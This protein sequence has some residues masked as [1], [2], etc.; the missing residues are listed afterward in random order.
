[1]RPGFRGWLYRA[2]AAL[3]GLAGL[4]VFLTLSELSRFYGFPRFQP[5]AGIGLVLSF[6]LFSSALIG[7]WSWKRYL[8]VS[9]GFAIP[10]VLGYLAFRPEMVRDDVLKQL[11]HPPLSID[12]VG[13]RALTLQDD[14]Q[15]E[16]KIERLQLLYA[17]V[18]S[19]GEQAA[20]TPE[21]EPTPS[22]H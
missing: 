6:L 18:R 12:L 8:V 10:V 22:P 19:Y 5:S 21:P 15:R 4:V 1:M 7:M 13:Y 16:L 11:T 17:M 9:L 14:P 20:V 3:F 2:V